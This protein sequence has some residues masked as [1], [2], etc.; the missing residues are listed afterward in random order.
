MC[1][2][3]KEDRKLA[4]DATIQFVEQTLCNVVREMPEMPEILENDEVLHTEAIAQMIKKKVNLNAKDSSGR[5]LLHKALAKGNLNA[6]QLLMTCYRY[7]HIV[8]QSN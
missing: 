4:Y 5:T 8:D 6:T 2:V 3:S 1:P 7:S